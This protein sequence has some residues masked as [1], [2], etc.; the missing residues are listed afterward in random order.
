V[1]IVGVDRIRVPHYR[2]KLA[3]EEVVGG[4]AVSFTILRSTQF[5]QLVEQIRTTPGRLGPLILDRA[6]LMRPVHMDDVADRIAAGLAAEPQGG[7]SSAGRRHSGLGEVARRWQLARG[8]S[9]PVLPV[10][11]PSRIGRE[12]RVGASTTA[13]QPT[14]STTWDDHL[15]QRYGARR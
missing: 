13:A 8:T 14:G 5:P 15:A 3:A 9:R 2:A 7:L 1:S 6:V 10:R 4:G 12:L 11:I